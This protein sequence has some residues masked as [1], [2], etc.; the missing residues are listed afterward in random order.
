MEDRTHRAEAP[1][2]P[3]KVFALRHVSFEV[4][5]ASLRCWHAAEMRSDRDAGTDFFADVDP[6]SPSLT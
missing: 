2:S 4:L 3:R 1:G 6:L 5:A